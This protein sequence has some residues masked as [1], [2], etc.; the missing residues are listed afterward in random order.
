M[1]DKMSPEQ[2]IE[3]LR[4]D[5]RYCASPEDAEKEKWTHHEITIAEAEGIAAL[6]ESLAADAAIGRAAAEI[7][8]QLKSRSQLVKDILSNFKDTMMQAKDM[9]ASK[10]VIN[11]IENVHTRSLE[12]I[13][14]RLVEAETELRAGNGGGVDG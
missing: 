4:D 14:T 7:D 1:D 10:A 3:I 8:K 2:A 9:V 5:N 12:S 11:L 13:I 6:I